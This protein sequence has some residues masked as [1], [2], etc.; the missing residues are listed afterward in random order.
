MNFQEMMT[1]TQKIRESFEEM[2]WEEAI[3]EM[4]PGEGE[5]RRNAA[6]ELGTAP[7]PVTVSRVMK[8]LSRRGRARGWCWRERRCD[9]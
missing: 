4:F 9:R 3:V 5:E 7:R 2:L 8:K 1:G 6:K